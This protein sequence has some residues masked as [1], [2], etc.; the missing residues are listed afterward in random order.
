MNAV[1]G[2]G[3]AAK[4]AMTKTHSPGRTTVGPE[5]SVGR[6][7]DLVKGRVLTRLASIP[8]AA[9]A[10]RF[11]PQRKPQ[12]ILPCIRFATTAISAASAALCRGRRHRPRRRAL[13]HSA[14]YAA[15]AAADS[16]LGSSRT[17][18]IIPK[19]YVSVAASS[20]HPALGPRHDSGSYMLL[21]STRESPVGSQSLT[22]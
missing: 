4:G 3:L 2:R 14:D 21:L 20:H 11:G 22:Q 8:G 5:A 17:L 16:G 15:A 12:V 1:S 10:A 7:S 9:A 13:E 18:R 6:S 19:R